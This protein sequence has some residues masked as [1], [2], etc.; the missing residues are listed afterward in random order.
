MVPRISV[1]MPA[2]NGEKYVAKA[3]D[4]IL[5]QTFSDFEFIVID[6]GS[7]DGTADILHSYTDER[8][9]VHRLDHGGIVGALNFGVAQSRTGWIARQDADDISMPGRIAQQW[10]AVQHNPKAVLCFTDISLLN[11][12]EEKVG[13]ARLP[14]T[15]AFIALRLCYQCPITHSTVLFNKDAFAAAGG[16]RAAERHAEDYALWG[17]MLEQGDFIALPNRLV[18]LRVHPQSVSKQNLETQ[19]ALTS[20]IAAEH[21]ARFMRLNP[22]DAVRAAKILARIPGQSTRRD[23]LWFMTHCVSGLRWWSREAFA[24]L[25]WQTAKRTLSVGV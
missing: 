8:L 14:R 13:R 15:R 9:K 3:V 21:C 4:S 18:E 19:L 24:W 7:S 2:W 5:A 12:S 22:N 1:V 6:D 25:A 17:R 20:G 10:E 16:Y 11:E 23:W